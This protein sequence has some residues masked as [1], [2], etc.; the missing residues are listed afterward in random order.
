MLT[1]RRRFCP[2][3]DSNNPVFIFCVWVTSG[4]QG[5]SLSRILGG[6]SIEPFF[7]RGGPR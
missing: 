3:A 1:G 7:L 4:A 2:R 6:S 5:V